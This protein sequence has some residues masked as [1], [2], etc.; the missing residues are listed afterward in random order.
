L[1]AETLAS[2]ASLM[3]NQ[4]GFTPEGDPAAEAHLDI[5]AERLRLLFVGITRAKKELILTWNTG[6]RGN[7]QPAL[8]F[9]ALKNIHEQEQQ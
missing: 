2:L 4:A 5:A 1:Q 7:C 9:L 3:V 6:K 8:A